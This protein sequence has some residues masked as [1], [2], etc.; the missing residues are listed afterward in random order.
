MATIFVS[1]IVNSLFK[2]SI[3][4]E[5]ALCTY[6]GLQF[7]KSSFKEEMKKWLLEFKEEF[8]FYNQNI[9]RI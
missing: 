6:D 2:T 8:Y 4:N 9:N 7:L 1:P 5:I 3:E